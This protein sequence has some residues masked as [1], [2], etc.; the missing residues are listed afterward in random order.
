MGIQNNAPRQDQAA[1]A[2]AS[3]QANTQASTPVNNSQHFE[4]TAAKRA[5]STVFGHLENLD[6]FIQQLKVKSGEARDE[7]GFIKYDEKMSAL[8]QDDHVN[9]TK[10]IKQINQLSQQK[11]EKALNDLTPVSSKFAF[12]VL[13]YKV[14]EIFN[15][16][17]SSAKEQGQNASEA[18]SKSD[19]R[20]ATIIARSQDLGPIAQNLIKSKLQEDD[21]KAESDRMSPEDKKELGEMLAFFPGD[22]QRVDTTALVQY[23]K[24]HHG[25]LPKDIRNIFDKE[26]QTT[27]AKAS[28]AKNSYENV[29]NNPDLSR[30]P[31]TYV[32]QPG[33]RAWLNKLLTASKGVGDYYN[34]TVDEAIA[35]FNP[36]P[37]Q[38]QFEVSYPLVTL[39]RG[40]RPG[41]EGASA[42]YMMTPTQGYV[43]QALTQNI[44]SPRFIMLEGA[45]PGQYVS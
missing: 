4:F 18:D 14:P 44:T 24:N 12:N 9:K 21:K 19:F 6:A 35:T 17:T 15:K 36:Q 22:G 43:N 41:F 10:E 32:G 29:H 5:V 40:F 1:P 2:P 37:W 3:S 28:E 20:K 30:L 8:T 27:L 23:Y 31:E 26:L 11:L 33:E 45:D 34:Y 42:K 25:E 39:V 13:M 38:P 16:Y 7:D